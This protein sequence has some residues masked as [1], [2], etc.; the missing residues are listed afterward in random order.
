METYRKGERGTF[1][2]SILVNSPLPLRHQANRH[3]SS[4]GRR[5]PSGM[6]PS[7]S[8]HRLVSRMTNLMSGRQQCYSWLMLTGVAHLEVLEDVPPLGTVE[9]EHEAP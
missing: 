2:R 4:L 9:G 5:Q 7:R 8:P 6:R 1:W 3:Y